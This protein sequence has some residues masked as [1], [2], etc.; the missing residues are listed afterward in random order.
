MNKITTNE[1]EIKITSGS[2]DYGEYYLGRAH[3]Y[4]RWQLGDTIPASNPV[5]KRWLF[6]LKTD[7]KRTCA[8]DAQADA[9]ILAH[10]ILDQNNIGY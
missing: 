4:E 1:V 7:I 6:T 10:D 9:V 5:Y 3:V 2:Y 8:E